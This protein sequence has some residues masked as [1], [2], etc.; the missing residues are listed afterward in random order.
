MAH[1]DA[2]GGRHILDH[3]QAQREAE[4]E[5]DGAAD[6][7]R[8]ESVASVRGL[9]RWRHAGPDS[10]LPAGGQPNSP[11]LDGALPRLRW[12]R[13]ASRPAADLPAIR[14]RRTERRRQ[15]TRLRRRPP[16]NPRTMPRIGGTP[17]RSRHVPLRRGRRGS[18]PPRPA[19]PASFPAAHPRKSIDARYRRER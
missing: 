12:L 2:S 11:Q 6:D 5:P 1:D 15:G 10:R 19:A 9:G 16:A 4:V 13:S 7:L 8:R 3:P 14:C 18:F 17:G